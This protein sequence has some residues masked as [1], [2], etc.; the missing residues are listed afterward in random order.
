[1][2]ALLV[3]HGGTVGLLAESALALLVVGALGV[4]WAKERRRRRT[5]GERL[6]PMRDESD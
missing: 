3:G 6:A 1:L 5:M 2:T 4:I